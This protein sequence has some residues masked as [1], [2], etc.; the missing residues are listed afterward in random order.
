MKCDSEIYA[1]RDGIEVKRVKLHNG[2]FN[3]YMVPCPKC[4]RV[5]ARGR[6]D[7]EKVYLCDYCKKAQTAKQK[8][9]FEDAYANIRSPK[10]QQFD[11]AVD[12]LRT[13]CKGFDLDRHIEVAEKRCESYGSVPEAMTAIMLLYYGYQIIP[14]QKVG[15]IRVDFCLPKQKIV[16]EVDGSIYHSNKEKEQQRDIQIQATLGFEWEV[17]H[18]PAEL[19]KQNP[20]KINSAI[21]SILQ[22]RGK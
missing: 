3:R 19:V 4:G 2:E 5:V 1:E 18:L 12:L 9:I 11:K 15:S 16:I 8:V 7:T 21:K 17:I 10:E 14:Q 6:Y 22:H 13:K 20:K